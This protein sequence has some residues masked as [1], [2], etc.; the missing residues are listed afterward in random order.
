[1][2]RSPRRPRESGSTIQRSPAGQPALSPDKRR[3]LALRLQRRAASVAAR[4][5]STAWAPTLLAS[6]DRGELARYATRIAREAVPEADIEIL[7]DE[8][9]V[10]RVGP[11]YFPDPSLFDGGAP[12][13]R[14]IA[15]RAAKHVADAT[16]YWF[17]LYQPGP[18]DVIIDIGAGRGEDVF[19]FSG[20]VGPS[21]RVLA[22]EAHPVSF[23]ALRKFCGLNRLTNVTPMNYACV[24]AHTDL[25]IESQGVWES[26]F[27]RNGAP[28]AASFAV[29]G[30]PLDDL[31]EQEGITR[32]DFLKMNIEGAEKSALAGC[33]KTL[34]LARFVCVAAHDFRAGRGEGEQF[35]TLDYVRR[36]LGEAGF[37][38][39]TR[40]DDPR[41][42]VPFHVHG[43][44][45][46]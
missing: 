3:L 12:D 14:K 40:D 1:M 39:L 33:R 27:V 26:S 17:H 9:W 31:C 16:D 20:A 23:A 6:A 4:Q 34:A 30:V 32:I 8:I 7:W 2:R 19:A 21:G 44:R 43:F 5:P 15:S 18:G 22:I 24:E 13:W 25:H 38:T 41:Y 29:T 46:Y 11:H 36:F 37:E 35:R 28:S 42:Y 10:C 45:V